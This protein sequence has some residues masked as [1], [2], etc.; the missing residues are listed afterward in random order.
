[1]SR[2]VRLPDRERHR[3]AVS[4]SEARPEATDDVVHMPRTTED[5]DGTVRNGDDGISLLVRAT[6]ARTPYA[7]RGPVVQQLGG[8]PGCQFTD[9]PELLQVVGTANHRDGQP[10]DQQKR[11][12]IATR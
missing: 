8:I 9:L 11:N 5:R 10:V 3:E 12:R 1:M 6:A 7:A 2:S 4:C